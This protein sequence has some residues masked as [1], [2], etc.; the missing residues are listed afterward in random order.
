MQ[1]IS[2]EFKFTQLLKFTIPT[3][4]MMMFLSLYTIVDGAFVSR[5][6]GTDALSA[7][8]IVFP[9]LGVQGGMSI[10]FATGSSAIVS[11]QLGEG[12]P[13]LANNTFSLISIV[14]SIVNILFAGIVLI[15][16]DQI[17][18]LLGATETL[19]PM[20]KDYLWILF[21][22]S[23]FSV[24]QILYQ[25]FFVTAGKPNLGF[26]LTIF[27]GLTNIVLDYVFIAKLHLGVAGAAYATAIGYC[28]P[29]IVGIVFFIINKNGLHYKLTK[30]D[31]RSIFFT[32]TNGSS[33]MVTNISLSVIT[34][35]FNLYM[36]KM[37]GSNGVAAV[38][39]I[40]YVQF[41]MVALFL[42]FSIGVAPVFG[43]H[44]G[45]QNINYLKKLTKMCYIF[46]I[47]MSLVIF[48]LSILSASLITKIFTK[49]NVEVYN[50]AVRGMKLFAIGYLFAGINIFSS[51]MF[52]A[53]S[54]GLMS[55]IISFMRTFVF[56]IISIVALTSLFDITGLWLAI[57]LS[58]LLTTVL[59]S[60]I[61]CIK[62]KNK[63]IYKLKS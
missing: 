34:V 30:F 10:M 11:K 20:C 58:E 32:C 23:P 48:A 60:V 17:I 40:F 51:G 26:G 46:V 44:Y 16:D 15:F 54:N 12:K 24:F 61:I 47:V 8:N 50:I 57:P 41:L 4:I 37:L 43:Y 62:V 18:T 1:N 13:I 25:N 5:Y 21:I 56:A 7:I 27:A 42:G 14:A 53:L 29:A 19:M 6:V 59:C 9:L 3:T 49:D 28:I 33:E 22:F 2:R 31:G 63:T 55:A 36:M 39:I 52:T 35:A 45:A 38:T